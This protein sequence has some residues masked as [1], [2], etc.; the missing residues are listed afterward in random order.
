MGEIYR[1]RIL[2]VMKITIIKEQYYNHKCPN[3]PKVLMDVYYDNIY[4]LISQNN[5][6]N[7]INAIK[8]INTIRIRVNQAYEGCNNFHFYT[9]VN[10]LEEFHFEIH[11]ND[12]PYVYKF[13]KTP[14]IRCEWLISLNKLIPLGN[15]ATKAKQK[16]DN[17]NFIIDEKRN[18]RHRVRK[19]KNEYKKYLLLKEKFDY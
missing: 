10:G 5:I 15:I 12:R 14:F 18:T 17:I 19:L 16:I 9:S 4:R 8:N 6:L 13:S 1:I 7:D 2:D 3:I 11:K